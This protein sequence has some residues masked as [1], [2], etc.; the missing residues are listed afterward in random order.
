MRKPGMSPWYRT[1][2]RNAALSPSA[3]PIA[4]KRDDNGNL[5]DRG[6]DEFEWDFEDRMI[7]ATVN[8]VTSTFTYRGDGLRNSRTVGGGATTTFTWDIASGLPVVLDDGS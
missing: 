4:Y 3:S 7:E 2:V 5:T 8:S 1:G 6:S